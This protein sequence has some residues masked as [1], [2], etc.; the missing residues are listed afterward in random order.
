[1]LATLEQGRSS[2][3]LMTWPCFRWVSL[4]A[5]VSIASLG[6]SQQAA[7]VLPQ[8]L[9]R[10][11]VQNELRENVNPSSHFQFLDQHQTVH[12]SQIKLMVETREATAGMIVAQNGAPLGPAQRDAENARLQ[13]Y[14]DHP[15]E[16]NRKRRQEKE[17]AERTIR[18][19][20]AMPDAFL[21]EPDGSQ[22]GTSDVGRPGH[23]LVRLK[24][25]PNP[26]YDPPSRVE[27]VLTGMVGNLLI[28]ADESRI[29]EINGTL[30]KQVGFGWG[31]LGHLDRGGRFLVRQADVGNNHW[32]VTRMELEFTGKVLLF[33]S[34]NIRSTD[35]FSGFRPVPADLTF[36]Q[37]V[38]LLK[39]EAASS[40]R[41]QRDGS[42]LPSANSTDSV[43]PDKDKM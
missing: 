10:N 19:I 5:M 12:L 1:M 20:K 15:E 4:A 23:Q 39:K 33:K 32:E 28:D 27:Q 25:R 6:Y 18:I 29:A 40:E 34:L 17:D 13:N 24:F 41:H 42:R 3:Y 16:L 30:Q 26:R 31:I 35:I 9:V 11:V 14:I 37:G 21:Y 43:K 8:E 38:E 22:T 36:A 2:N 7:N